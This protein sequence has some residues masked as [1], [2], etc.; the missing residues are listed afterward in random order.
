MPK[1][2]HPRGAGCRGGL[3]PKEVGAPPS[4]NGQQWGLHGGGS[5]LGWGPGRQVGGLR[6]PHWQRGLERAAKLPACPET[7]PPAL[8]HPPQPASRPAAASVSQTTQQGRVTAPSFSRQ[9]G[10]RGPLTQSRLPPPLAWEGDPRRGLQLGAPCWGTGGWET[11][12]HSGS[13]RG[14]AGIPG[15]KNLH[16][17]IYS[18]GISVVE[19]KVQRGGRATPPPTPRPAARNLSRGV[20]PLVLA[21]LRPPAPLWPRTATT[22]APCPSPT[23]GRTA[24][25]RRQRDLLRT[26]FPE[27]T[28][29]GGRRLWFKR[30]VPLCPP[31]AGGPLASTGP[32]MHKQEGGNRACLLWGQAAQSLP[33]SDLLPGEG[34]RGSPG[35]P[36]A[37]SNLS[38][39]AKALPPR[40]YRRPRRRER[41]AVDQ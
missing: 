30:W 5:G 3:S 41:M 26:Q 8:D 15:P 20:P 16:P 6:Q 19:A 22:P 12:H 40:P 2:A 29:L 14:G 39:S 24:G 35:S 17:Q 27:T 4:G 7:R 10:R 23:A 1:V 9:A 25:S 33:A 31:Q 13:I 28:A 34:G 11:P 38:P 36:T 18:R 37:S 32:R 21:L